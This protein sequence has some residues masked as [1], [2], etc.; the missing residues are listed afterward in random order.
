[1]IMGGDYDIN[2]A[3][4]ILFHY[5]AIFP[6]KEY[7]DLY[8]TVYQFNQTLKPNQRKFRILNLSYVYDWSKFSEHK[9][10]F[11][12]DEIFYK[13]D[14]DIYRAAIIKEHIIDKQEKILVLTGT[15]HA[16]TKSNPVSN[17]DNFLGGIIHSH[18]PEKTYTIQFHEYLG[19][20]N[21]ILDIENLID[22]D[23]E[24]YYFDLSSSVIGDIKISFRSSDDNHTIVERKLKDIFDGYIYH[25]NLKD[26]T[27]CTIDYSFLG[28]HSIEDV[29]K[30]FPDPNWHEVPNTLQ[31]YW[32]LVNEYVDLSKRKAI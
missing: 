29:I 13:G 31:E 24:Q 32:E 14:C 1:M 15:I 28:E 25:T 27:G 6:Y 30:N 3:R 19:E 16:Y 20:G 17:K 21:E 4:D 26:R 9:I 7:M 11:G 22:R 10:G 18:L 5:N 12:R 8:Y 2:I 23:K